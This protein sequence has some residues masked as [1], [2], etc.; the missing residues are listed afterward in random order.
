MKTSRKVLYGVATV[1]LLLA[2]APVVMLGVLF[3]PYFLD[4]L[5]LDRAV[6]SA[7]QDWRDFGEDRGRSRLEYELDQHGIGL[8]VPDDACTFERDADRLSVHCAW[9]VVVAV[10][11]VDQRVPLSFTSVASVL[12]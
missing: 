5:A 11:I 1:V 8:H 12:P 3:G 9:E 7:A 10:P 4:D 6:G 2:A